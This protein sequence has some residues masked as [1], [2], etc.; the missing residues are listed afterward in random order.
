MKTAV[1]DH[2][3]DAATRLRQFQPERH[4]AAETEPAA[5]EPDIALRSRAR[6]MF[7]KNWAIADRFV[8]NDIILRNLIPQR[9]EHERRIKRAGN[10][11]VAAR[12]RALFRR[13]VPRAGPTR[14]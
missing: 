2:L 5:G 14:D 11:L 12:R 10:A 1:A 7:L 8:E 13:R 3:H 6:E 9:R 4:A